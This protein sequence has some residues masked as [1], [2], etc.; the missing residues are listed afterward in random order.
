MRINRGGIVLS[1]A[2]SA[3]ILAA[4][5]EAQRALLAGTACISAVKLWSDTGPSLILG[6]GGWGNIHEIRRSQPRRQVAVLNISG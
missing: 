5:M 4:Y 3:L 2:A 6:A 1:A